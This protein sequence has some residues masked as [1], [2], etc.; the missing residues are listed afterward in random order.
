MAI[1]ERRRAIAAVVV[2]MVVVVLVV[3]LAAAGSGGASGPPDAAARLVPADALAYVHVSTD[4][5]RGGVRRATALARRFPDFSSL[6]GGLLRRLTRPGC[7]GLGAAGAHGREVAVAVLPAG[8]LLLVDTGSG[9]AVRRP[10]RCGTA[11]A[12][13]LGRFVVMGS[14]LAVSAALAVQRGHEPSLAAAALYRAARRDLPADRFADGYLSAGGLR[15]FLGA[16]G[17]LG[18]MVSR[19]LDD[20]RLRGVGL[21]AEARSPGARLTVHSVLARGPAPAGHATGLLGEVPAGAMA[22]IDTGDLGATLTRFG[23]LVGGLDDPGRRA[24]ARAMP[25]EVA[26]WLTPVGPPRAPTLTLVAAHGD[27]AR[28]PATLGGRRLARATVDGRLVVSTRGS[29]IAAARAHGPRL[30]D[31][32]AARAVLGGAPDRVSALGFLD[33]SELLRLG[34]QSGLDAS[35]AYR[36]VSDDLRRVRAVGA[37]STGDAGQTTLQV[38]L[39]I[40]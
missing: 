16:R 3:A 37:V 25:G 32:P 24:L 30:R 26:L 23:T 5:G 19:L 9:T 22:A 21:A 36:G 11:T 34:E 10:R 14:S 17:D 18:A 7:G 29:G 38:E 27:A 33:F 40:P 39:S 20:P 8:T 12:E 1:H 15:G 35:R 2:V 31:T 28:L 4:P 13:R 6:D